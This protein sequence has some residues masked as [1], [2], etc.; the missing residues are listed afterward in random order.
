[1]TAGT[2]WL[3]HP[4]DPSMT[5]RITTP[6]VIRCDLTRRG[7]TDS[8]IRT[9]LANG[10]LVRLGRGSYADGP[11]FVALDP[12]DQAR[13]RI[14]AYA[15]RTSALVVSHSSAARWHRLPVLT[16]PTPVHVI[17]PGRGGQRRTDEVHVHAGRLADASHALVDG[18]D[19][20]DVATTVVDVA[21]TELLASAVVV[22]DAAL[23][24]GLV[25]PAEL[26]AALELGA[27]RR[28]GP[29]ARR[30]FRAMD[31]RAE[32]PGESLLRLALD[33]PALP[34]LE[35]QIDIAAESGQLIGRAD[36]GYLADGVLVEFDGKI[37]Y[38]RLRRTGET[39]Q[40]AVLREKRREERFAELGWLVIRV[41]WGELRSSARL[42]RR[43]SAACTARRPLVDRGGLRGSATPRSPLCVDA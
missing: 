30:A 33:D 41:T 19:V 32:S 39:I 16:P 43:V 13:L 42:I 24:R 25:T 3:R 14:E 5:L 11:A 12:D 29:A 27:S 1:M 21:R 20:T 7:Y 6:A 23:H 35:L 18:V 28:G 22:G 17:R 34:G 31:G 8:E 9:A 40:D 26:W 36:G 37:K 10:A 2:G 4:H 38:G 15:S